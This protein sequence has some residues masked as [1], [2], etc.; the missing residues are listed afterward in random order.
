MKF[1]LKN[2]GKYDFDQLIDRHGSGAL[3]VDALDEFY[4]R[5]DLLA[6]WV[7]D[8]DFAVAPRI[9]ASLVKRMEHPIYGY[10]AVPQSYWNSII[11]WLDRR[12]GWK[13]AREEITY[14]PGVVKAIG[15]AINYFTQPGD[16]ILIQPPVYHPF[17]RLV[18]GNKRILVNN[19]LVLDDS[20]RY[21]MDFDDLEAKFRER[22]PR[23][24]GS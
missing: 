22:L 8:M 15:Y 23:R 6:L 14:V 5:N 7:A 10:A 2:M 17:K 20:G 9:Q 19:P 16:P 13:V 18:E 1:N 11:D 4:G 21:R 12:H 3:K 24:T